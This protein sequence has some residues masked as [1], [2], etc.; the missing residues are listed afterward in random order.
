MSCGDSRRFS[1]KYVENEQPTQGRETF[2]LLH[3]SKRAEFVKCTLKTKIDD[4]MFSL[5]HAIG[6]VHPPRAV[7]VPMKC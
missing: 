6:V 5:K 2:D 3:C 4:F 7:T 1:E